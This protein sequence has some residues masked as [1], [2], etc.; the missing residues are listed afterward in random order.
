VPKDPGG[1]VTPWLRV[2]L[3]FRDEQIY[4]FRL[5]HGEQTDV[6]KITVVR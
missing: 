2:R 5:T 6:R 1:K 4:F 3:G